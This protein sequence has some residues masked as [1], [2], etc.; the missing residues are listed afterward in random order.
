MVR[1]QDRKGAPTFL[2]IGPG[3]GHQLVPGSVDTEGLDK[4][5]VGRGKGECKGKG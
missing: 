4:W 1:E 5:E 3:S 2:A